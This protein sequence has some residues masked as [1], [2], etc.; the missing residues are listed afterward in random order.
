MTLLA[1]LAPKIKNP[2]ENIA[3]EALGYILQRKVARKALEAILSGH[4]P[5]LGGIDRV[6]TQVVQG[7]TRPDLVGF[8]EG[9]KI[10]QI[11]A[12]FW[13]ALTPQ[14]P[15][16]YFKRLGGGA[17]LLFVA[18]RSRLEVLWTVLLDRLGE[19]GIGDTSGRGVKSKAIGGKHLMLTS[20]AHLLEQLR[21]S[22]E[23][24]TARAEINQVLGLAKRMDDSA[25]LQFRDEDFAPEIGRR[26]ATL[27]RLIV[28]AVARGKRDEFIDSKGLRASSA[29]GKIGRFIRVG[30]AGAWFGL[31]LRRWASGRFP[32]TP[33]W[34]RFRSWSRDSIPFED[35]Q[36]ALDPLMR[37]APPGCFRDGQDLI[38]P[39]RPQV[40]A[41][42]HEVLED[43]V[44]QLRE[45]AA[46]FREGAA[47]S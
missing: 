6:E 19:K 22:A 42:Y 32:D 26:L 15:E 39:I 33:L 41:D 8:R 38:V 30:G 13:A 21:T 31:H 47:G 46:L 7:P 5:D 4:G 23:D 36:S 40:G 14:Q 16:E 29:R 1:H 9:Q 24:E 45:I 17:T 2:T 20:W 10:L 25:P 3:V 11:E 35:I 43:V 28:E 27:D 12:K 44:R 37:Q 18:P 34:L